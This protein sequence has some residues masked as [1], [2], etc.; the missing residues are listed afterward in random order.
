MLLTTIPESGC[1][2]GLCLRLAPCPFKT[3]ALLRRKQE[4]DLTTINEASRELEEAWNDRFFCHKYI[5]VMDAIPT[6][7]E[8]KRGYN[9]FLLK[10]LLTCPKCACNTVWTSRLPNG[11]PD[12]IS[13]QGH[14]V[15]MDSVAPRILYCSRGY[16]SL[17][18]IYQSL[19]GVPFAATTDAPTPI[20]CPFRIDQSIPQTAHKKL[21]FFDICFL[22]FPASF[23]VQNSSKFLKIYVHRLHISLNRGDEPPGRFLRVKG[24]LI[25]I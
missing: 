14:N 5:Y 8:L 22:A 10:L 17:N 24:I 15:R 23:G 18:S 9:E 1:S 25:C 19:L 7:M 6:S 4:Y 13:C 21:T 2:G 16:M 12:A 3:S 20:P 11:L